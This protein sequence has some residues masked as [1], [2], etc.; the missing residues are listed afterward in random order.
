ME[1]LEQTKL[2]GHVMRLTPLSKKSITETPMELLSLLLSKRT[3]FVN[4]ELTALSD[5]LRELAVLHSML[6]I[7]NALS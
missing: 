6:L 1:L 3:S 5:V 7:T 2:K 4:P